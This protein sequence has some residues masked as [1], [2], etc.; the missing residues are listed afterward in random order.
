MNNT[1]YWKNRQAMAQT[2]ILNRNIK[3]TE[4]L[5]AKV[6]KMTM[7][8]V[9]SDYCSTYEKLLATMEEGKTPTPAD[10]YKLDKYY[11]MQND[12]TN[13]LRKLGYM[14]QDI[15]TDSF[16]QAFE[17]HYKAIKFANLP[18]Y[19]TLTEENIIQAINSI[20]CADGKSWSSRVWD[21][22][23][24][25]TETLNE[26]LIHCVVSG[27]NSSHL[28]KLLQ[29]RFDVSFSAADSLV[30][31]EMAHIQTEAA[32]KRYE[33]SGITQVQVWADKDERRCDVCGKLHQ[34]KFYTYEA[35]PIPAHP[36]CRC[37]IVPVVE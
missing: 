5:V 22:I 28:K 21:N 16:F 20:W 6:Y 31:T 32:R 8:R 36:R 3:D 24:D 30:R 12:I 11:E 17:E 34:K 2:K 33:D 25:L 14:Q 1:E 29:E 9:V 4:K 35:I 10:L 7:A 23:A 19:K 13:Q 37:C 27:R 26:E 18:E 15:L